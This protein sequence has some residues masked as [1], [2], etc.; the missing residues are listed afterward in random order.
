MRLFPPSPI[1]SRPSRRSA[2]FA[3]ALLAS[4]LAACA[5]DLQEDS[6][7]D[8]VSSSEGSTDAGPSTGTL[9]TG[10]TDGVT[11]PTGAVSSSS[12]EGTSH[13]E[14]TSADSGS[15]PNGSR[16][17][18]TGSP[19]GNGAGGQSSEGS[20]VDPSSS[21]TADNS[22]EG[23]GTSDGHLRGSDSPSNDP[24]GSDPSTNEPSGTAPSGTAPS[25][26]EPPGSAAP[27]SDPPTT[28]PSHSDGGGSGSDASVQPPWPE[29]PVG[30]FYLA[31]HTQ[32][33]T[34][35]REIPVAEQRVVEDIIRD[36]TH[37]F[38][39]MLLNRGLFQTAGGFHWHVEPEAGFYCLYRA[40]EGDA[41]PPVP[42]CP[43]IPEV[44][45]SHADLLVEAGVDFVFAD[46]TNLPEDN[47][48]ADLIGL[49][50]IEVLFEEWQAL[51]QSGVATPRI[52]A[53]VPATE[54]QGAETPLFRRV[55]ELYAQE[56][57]ADLLMRHEGDGDPVLFV[58]DN[59]WLPA[60]EAFLGEIRDAGVLPVRLWGNLQQAAL[61]GGTAGWM[62]PCTRDGQFTTLLHPEEPCAQF[63]SAETPIGSVVS[64]SAS[65]Q[66][67]YASLPWQA[68]GRY[69]G[70][71][72]QKQFETA[73]AVQPDYVLINAWNEHIAQP[74]DNPLDPVLGNARRSMGIVE[75]P[76][77]GS[78][79]WLWVDCYGH[80]LS[81]DIEPTVQGGWS[82]Y[83]LMASCIRTYRLG[84][85]PCGTPAGA[86]ERCCQLEPGMR[87]V[88]VLQL[89][90]GRAWH[91]SAHLATTSQEERDALVNAGAWREVCNVGYGPP[92]HCGGATTPNGPFLVFAAGGEGRLPLW[93]C[94]KANNT[95]LIAT[96]DGCEGAL[97]EGVLGFI[98]TSPTSETPRPLRRCHNTLEDRHFHVLNDLCPAEQG[99]TDGGVLGWVR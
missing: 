49:R 54:A 8:D 98:A 94:L 6:A 23:D 5:A 11:E 67:G 15:Q 33:A 83:E 90:E 85:D 57:Y 66:V 10:R 80:D 52:A 29:R 55:L 74:Q 73:F 16:S 3:A 20:A 59:D 75:P 69:G 44:A 19:T 96:D 92:G 91:G 97:A 87:V 79:E 76:G 40:R 18:E 41:S 43:G 1:D 56:P 34:A 58:V 84:P 27:G 65:Y 37:F 36:P 38:S 9:R 93:R 61:D 81:R 48:F 22:T 95:H 88:R 7:L 32:A 35:M 89:Q 99:V 47:A 31:W 45:R 26:S 12:A 60:S 82:A 13:D 78:A 86:A 21:H 42:D 63:W 30:I 68:S 46:L 53:W 4:V 64:V 51:R 14:G 77:D 62:Q 2:L 71:T 28:G 72:L 25:S 50:P 39:S 17:G 70:L 24:P